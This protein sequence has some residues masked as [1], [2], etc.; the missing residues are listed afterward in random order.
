MN[1]IKLIAPCKDYLWGGNRLKA[2]FG[3]QSE[4]EII[5]ETWELSC[6]PDG[7]SRIAEGAHQRKTLA[8][9]IKEEGKS[10]LGENCAQFSD[11]PILVKLI[12]AQKDLSIQLHPNNNYAAQVEHQQGKTEMWYVVDCKPGASLYYGLARELTK[13]ELRKRIENNTLLEVLN[14]VEVHPGDVFFIEAGT[15]HAIGAGILIAEIQQNSNVTYRVYDYN[16]TDAQGNKRELHVQK[17]L[18]VISLQPIAMR[19]WKNHLASCRYF[20]VDKIVTESVTSIYADTKSF[21]HLLCLNGSG[22][23]KYTGNK[24]EFKKGES[25]FIPAGLGNCTLNGC[26]EALHTWVPTPPIYR[27]GIDLGGTNIA[28]GIVDKHCNIV[29]KHSVPTKSERPYQ[30]IVE[31]MAH[32]VLKV[33][34]DAKISLE[35]CCSIGIGSP[36]ICDSKTG[37]VLYSNNI[38]WEDVPLAATLQKY[39]DL[40]CTISNDANCAALGEVAAKGS[41]NAVM[42]TLGTGVGGGVVL[43]GK[44]FSG[45]N[46]AGAELGHMVLV[47]NG[48]TCTCG[49]QGCLEA[50]ASASAL[51]KQTKKAAKD[52]PDSA[53]WT[54]CGGNLEQI[55][56]RT[57]FDAARQGDKTGQQV[58]D[59]Y[60]SYLGEGIVDLVNI[61]RPECVI[62]GGGLCNEGS[63]LIDPIQAFVARYCFGRNKV[64]PPKV[65]KAA[66]GNDAGI[67]GAAL[68]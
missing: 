52:Y 26:F 37:T 40:P 7:P 49:R 51:I 68:L 12:D 19:K 43:D 32:A 28:V 4:K 58:V 46:C 35:Q 16:R 9:Y 61:F 34:E 8:Q 62:I 41:T 60:L 38:K 14:R 45:C 53:I 29:A 55:T 54:L 27:I 23:L 67:I 1:P 6:H 5:A 48:E 64:A 44:I 13:Q 17:A 2:E 22:T 3:K 21:H 66:L 24:V 65:I 11:F 56:G 30:E 20:T 47:K 15:I 33:L 31:D 63:S 39:I 42:L 36:G 25:F 10:I 50:Y 18:D 59:T 57:A